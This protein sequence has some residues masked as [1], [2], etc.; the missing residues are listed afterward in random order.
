MLFNLC[1][2]PWLKYTL[3]AIA[4]RGLKASQWTSA[5]LLDEVLL[6]ETSTARYQVARTGTANDDTAAGSGRVH[7]VYS[8]S[9]CKVV[10]P[11]GA[12][13]RSGL[14]LPAGQVEVLE[15]GLGWEELQWGCRVLQVRG[16][17]LPVK[18]MHFAAL[19]KAKADA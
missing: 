19:C 8:L 6:L 12:M 4:D 11:M 13:R 14:P 1:N 15:E 5:R 9:K 16:R 3:P 17:E 18:R 2:E 7:D 10:L